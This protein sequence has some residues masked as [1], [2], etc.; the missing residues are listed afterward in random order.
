MKKKNIILI[1]HGSTQKSWKKTFIKI[2]KL[3]K[4]RNSNNKISIYFI[5]SN[6]KNIIN[7]INAKNINIIVPIFLGFGYHIKYDIKNIINY[8]KKKYNNL[9]IILN[10][11]I[12]FN[13]KIIFS[14]A[15][16]IIN[17]F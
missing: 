6:I 13:K 17:L 3:I 15:I 7:K 12:I 2:L 4:D 10:N 1:S 14:I 5:E 9:K 16:N 11:N 8:L